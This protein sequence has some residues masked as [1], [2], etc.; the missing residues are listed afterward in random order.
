MAR[1]MNANEWEELGRLAHSLSGIAGTLGAINL[2]D[3]LLMVEDAARLE[4][5]VH[6][7]TAL[8]DVRSTWERTRIMILPRFEALAAARNRSAPNRAA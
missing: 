7:D 1:L 6:V 8:N 3:G 4:G 2:A 5:Q